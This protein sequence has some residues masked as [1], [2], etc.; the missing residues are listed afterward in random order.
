MFMVLLKGVQSK[1]FFLGHKIIKK[2]VE[3]NFF[4][5]TKFIIPSY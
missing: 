1:Y 3:N 2:N 4:Q 5:P